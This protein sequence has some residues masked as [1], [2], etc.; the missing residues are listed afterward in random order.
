MYKPPKIAPPNISPPGGW[1]LEFALEYKVKRV[2]C[3]DCLSR[4]LSYRFGGCCFQ[5]PL[6]SMQEYLRGSLPKSGPLDFMT[7]NSFPL[8]FCR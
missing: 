8:F 7:K 2:S 6:T 4:P 3:L 1:Y 5:S